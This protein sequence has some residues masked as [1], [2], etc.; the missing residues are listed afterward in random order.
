M[1]RND[2]RMGLPE[3]SHE[4]SGIPVP[5]AEQDNTTTQFNW[6]VPTE[7]VPLP[8]RGL[9][10]PEGHPLHKQETVE[11]RYMTAKEEDILTSQA[12]LKEGLA[13]DRALQSLM[14]D[15]RIKITDLLVGDKNALVIASRITGYGEEYE[16]SV[17]CPACGTTGKHIFDLSDLDYSDFEEKM[18]EHG[19]T[20]SERNIFTVSLP[21]SKAEVEC[22]LLTGADENKVFKNSKRNAKKKESSLFTDQLRLIIKSVNGQEGSLAVAA[23]V[24]QMPARDARYLRKVFS[25]VSPNVDM[26]Q[27]FECSTCTYTA[28]MEVPLTSDF[29]WPR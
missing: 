18:Q 16:T 23:F 8:S 27:T 15:K 5:V 22:R 29:L 24:Q 20:I 9:F 17:T 6:S 13:V 14:V 19:V 1:N 25:E 12:L 7:V 3:V 10:Y 2:G 11:I 26:N 4:G 21:F 28:D